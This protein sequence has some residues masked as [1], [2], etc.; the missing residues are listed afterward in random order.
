[1]QPEQRNESS[2]AKTEPPVETA[3]RIIEEIDTYGDPRLYAL[4]K[5]YL[6]L[7]EV[8]DFLLPANGCHTVDEALAAFT[9]GTFRLGKVRKK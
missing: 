2:A 4:A 8:V 9:A 5:E 7:R 6:R 1:M 3:K